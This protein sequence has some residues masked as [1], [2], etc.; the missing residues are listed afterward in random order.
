MSWICAK[1]VDF[2]LPSSFQTAR[3][4][5]CQSQ[6]VRE[7]LVSRIKI[8]E[9]NFQMKKHWEFPRKLGRMYYFKIKV[10]WK[11]FDSDAVSNQ[12]KLWPSWICCVICIGTKKDFS[13]SFEQNVQWISRFAMMCNKAGISGKGIWSRLNSCVC[14]GTSNLLILVKF[15][16]YFLITFL[17]HLNFVM[18]NVDTSGWLKRMAKFCAVCC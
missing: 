7:E 8:Y 15:H 18:G 12:F 10:G 14:K 5:F 11:T 16:Q 1:L 17:M 2:T 3:S 9:I 13:E 4:C 6:R